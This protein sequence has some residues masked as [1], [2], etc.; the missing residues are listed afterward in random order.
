MEVGGSEAANAP[1]DARCIQTTRSVQ[2]GAIAGLQEL[3]HGGKTSTFREHLHNI[4]KEAVLFPADAAD[5]AEDR[6]HALRQTIDE[7]RSNTL[8]WCRAQVDFWLNKL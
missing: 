5:F 4:R 8:R 7:G 1:N 3:V 6:F 2:R